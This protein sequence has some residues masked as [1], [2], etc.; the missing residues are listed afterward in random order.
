MP[1]NGPFVRS[2]ARSSRM[3]IWVMAALMVP[4]SIYSVLYRSPF[5]FQ[6]VGYALL[7]MLAEGVYA[8][9]IQRKIRFAGISSG[10][11][12]ALIAASVPPTMPFLPMLYAILIAVWIVKLPNRRWAFRLNAAMAGRLFL[13]LV[14]SNDVVTWGNASV[15]VVSAATPQ[16]L[17]RGEGFAIDWHTLLFGRIEGVWEELFQMVPG[18]PGETF[19][20]LLLLIGIVLCWKGIAAWRAPLAYLLSFCTVT[21][22]CGNSPWFNLFSAA[23]VFTAVFIVSDPVST[24]MSKSGKIICGIIMGASNAL[25]RHYTYYTEAVVYAVLIGNACSPLLDRI[26]FVAEGWRLQRRIRRMG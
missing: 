6:M 9:L 13:M 19:P 3:A 16:E 4:A 23:T 7:G 2:G 22:L 10:L 21:A 25:I 20:V 5:I 14:Y 17:Y 18:S 12:A 1:V 26:A 24:P 11:T 15:D 8:L